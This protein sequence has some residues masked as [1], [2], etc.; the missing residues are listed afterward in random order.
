MTL[1]ALRAWG[2]QHGVTAPKFG[3]SA[4]YRRTWV[5]TQGIEPGGNG[6]SSLGAVGGYLG[7]KLVA[8][9]ASCSVAE[10]LISVPVSLLLHA[11]VG[12]NDPT[13]GRALSALRAEVGQELDSRVM[14]ALTL[15]LERLKGCRSRW[16]TYIAHLPAQY[17]AKAWL[18]Y[19]SCGVD[20]SD[21]FLAYSA[22]CAARLCLHTSA[23]SSTGRPLPHADDP[24][25][26]DE[27]DAALLEGSCAAPV[28]RGYRLAL[29]KLTEW[30]DRLFAL[31]AQLG[32]S[33]PAG[34]DPQWALSAE[35][36]RWCRS[37]VWS[38]AFNATLDGSKAVV[39]VPVCA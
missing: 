16:A 10:R 32:G 24:T 38:R 18:P 13:Y 31:H 30:R 20:S 37:T 21:A 17:G 2:E 14:L 8:N 6:I 28:L 1:Q 35:A 26:W 3:I 7:L 23:D 27:H 36:L 34:C 25:W 39:L 11:E 5:A 12:L 15:L 29:R 9:K 19:A 22:Q 33:V 4:D